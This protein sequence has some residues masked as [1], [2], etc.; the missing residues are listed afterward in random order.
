MTHFLVIY[1][2]QLRNVHFTWLKQ[3]LPS[4][5]NKRSF[6]RLKG[7]H[8]QNNNNKKRRAGM[9]RQNSNFGGS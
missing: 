7:A 5:S 4:K 6:S 8:F 9:E 2:R 3:P 1:R